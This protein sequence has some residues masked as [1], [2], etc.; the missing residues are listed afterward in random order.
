M[1]PMTSIRAFAA[2]LGVAALAGCDKNAVQDI[3]APVTSAA[4][5]FHNY[6]VGTPGVNLY[7][8]GVKVTGTNSTS[9][10][11]ATDPRCLAE[12]IESTSGTTYG[13]VGAGGNY[14]V[15]PA[16]QQTLTSR[17]TATTDN[18]LA[19]STVNAPLEANRFYSYFTSGIYNTTTKT[20]DAFVVEDVLPTTFDYSKAYLRVVNASSNAGPVSMT[21]QLVGTTQVVPVA[22]NIGYQQASPIVTVTPGS[23]DLTFTVGTLT[24]KATGVALLGG[25]VATIVLRGDRNAATT[26]ANYLTISSTFNR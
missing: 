3:T 24:V 21:T 22:T 12:G 5:R 13:N 9:C 15:V 25:H 7:A 6:G 10:T 8:N 14:V 23:T 18:G 16:G 1:A 20:V 11:P 26:S 19:V 2:L 17:I 4:V